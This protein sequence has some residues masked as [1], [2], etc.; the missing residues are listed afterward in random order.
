MLE[1][2]RK[3]VYPPTYYSF[4]YDPKVAA[5]ERQAAQELIDWCQKHA[6]KDNA[7]RSITQ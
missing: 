6:A 7:L 2:Y 3:G 4:Y 1:G 5:K